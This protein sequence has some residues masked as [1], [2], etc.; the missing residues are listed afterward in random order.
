VIIIYHNFVLW[1]I[2]LIVFV[3]YISHNNIICFVVRLCAIA[4]PKTI[5]V[6]AIT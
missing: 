6:I 5:Q 2:V 3:S 1:I 4:F